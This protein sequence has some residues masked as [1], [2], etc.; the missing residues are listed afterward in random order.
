MSGRQRLRLK[1]AAQLVVPTSERSEAGPTIERRRQAAHEGGFASLR[2][3]DAFGFAG[4]GGSPEAVRY[5]L[6]IDYLRDTGRLEPGDHAT[7][8][9][10]R[11]LY[12]RTG[13]RAHLVGRYA[14][15]VG[16]AASPDPAQEAAED[17]YRR[18]EMR[19][20]RRAGR[21]AWTALRALVIEDQMTT[22]WR[23][24]PMALQEA[25]RWL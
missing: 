4:G 14:E 8:L 9:A 15:R 6:M 24:L 19:V 17:R 23:S 7:A 5:P 1:G 18:L 3:E 12:E 11:E 16:R 2:Q 25:E 22:A 13:F 21:D 20:L 10:V